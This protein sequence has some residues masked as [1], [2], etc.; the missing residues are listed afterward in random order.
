MTI[1]KALGALS[2][3]VFVVAAGQVGAGQNYTG[4]KILFIDS[5]HEGYAWSD[6]IVNGARSVIDGSGAELRI[7]R[8][9]TKRNKSDAF[10][11][12]AAERV[13][14]VIE[15]YRPDVVI[16]ADD[17]ASKYVIQPYYKDAATPF[18]FCGVNWDA[19]SYGFPYVNVTGMLEV[20]AVDELF[21]LLRGLA[22][23][24]RI[25]YLAADVFTARKEKDRIQKTFY[26]RFTK[27]HFAK[28][29][30]EW[31]AAYRDLQGKVDILLVGNS[32]GIDDWD[33]AAAARFVEQ[34][35]K[36]PSGAIHPHMT[37]FALIGY[38]KIAE[39]QGEWAARTALR[40]L[41]GTPPL[42]IPIVRN[43]QG[44][45][46]VN[47]RIAGRLHAS[48]VPTA[49]VELMESADQVIE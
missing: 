35:S 42:A 39:E 25:G 46:T 10:K 27:A 1:K 13:R 33:N 38:T 8:M 30:A 9:D 3:L 48:S 34:H 15:T 23:G 45:L 12:A 5:Y 16:A 47:A 32:A 4:K 18:V 17:N 22:K 40:I 41:D 24:H 2:L 49:L 6:G 36:I 26:M 43:T 28:T 37:A 29:L 11:K 21:A 14:D 31:Q 19:L 7:V 44:R 20:A